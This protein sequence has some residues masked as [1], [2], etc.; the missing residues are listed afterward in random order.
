M[1]EPRRGEV[2]WAD[3]ADKRRPVLVLTRDRAIPVRH[4][5]LVAPI[6]RRARSIPTELP[7]DETDGMPEACAATFDN[8]TTAEKSMLVERITRLS[9]RR[10]EEACGV[11]E[12]ATGS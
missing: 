3:M 9:H 7:L 4:R 2:W 12:I 11:L 6:T 1:T 5:V 10:M 8:V